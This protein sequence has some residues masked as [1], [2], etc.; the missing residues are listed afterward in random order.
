MLLGYARVSDASQ[1]HDLQLDALRRAGCERIFVETA[2]GTRSD[3]PQLA[4]VMEFAR[5]GDTIAVWR[6]DRL[7]RSLRHLIDLADG[8]DRRGVGLRSLNESIDTTTASGRFLFTVLAAMGQMEVELLRERTRAGLR[9]A[10]SRGRLGG[11]PRALD[12]S[13]LRVAQ[14]LI[15]DGRLSVAEIAQQVGCAPSTLYRSLP[16]GRRGSATTMVATVPDRGGTVREVT[17]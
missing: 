10:A 9:A 15:A 13:K 7:A 2:L 16:G 12:A 1:N 3:R 14:A 17:A 8:L 5:K 6:L 11:R 4:E